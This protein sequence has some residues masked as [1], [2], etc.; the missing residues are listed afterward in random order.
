MEK[1]QRGWDLRN[2]CLDLQ[3]K[4]MVGVIERVKER[5]KK[6]KMGDRETNEERPQPYFPSWPFPE[7]VLSGVPGFFSAGKMGHQSQD[8]CHSEGLL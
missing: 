5:L 1:S 4:K 2:E 3:Q 7:C 6:N 8:L